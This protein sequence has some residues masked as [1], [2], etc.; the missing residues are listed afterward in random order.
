MGGKSTGEAGEYT[1]G[2]ENPIGE[3]AESIG[4]DNAEKKSDGVLTELAR[5][6]VASSVSKLMETEGF[7]REMMKAMGREFAAYIGR[8]IHGLRQEVVGQ[9][10]GAITDWLDKVNIADEVRKSLNGMTFDINVKVHVTDEGV[11][12][13]RAPKRKPAAGAK[14]GT[15]KP[16]TSGEPRSAG[17]SRKPRNPQ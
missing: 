4:L 8:E 5:K 1:Y 15:S 13:G 16:R 11:Q 17:K 7:V 12:S 9:A 3:M 6:A 2:S 10:T 14:A